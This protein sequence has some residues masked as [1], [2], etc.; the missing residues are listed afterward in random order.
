MDVCE[1][2]NNFKLRRKGA[3]WKNNPL[4]NV[5]I[6]RLKSYKNYDPEVAK[7]QEKCFSEN[8]EWTILLT[9]VLPDNCKKSVE[10]YQSVFHQ[11]RLETK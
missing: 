11:F 10:S 4:D 5:H 7:S 6:S 8:T 9:K 2:D 3:G 1:N